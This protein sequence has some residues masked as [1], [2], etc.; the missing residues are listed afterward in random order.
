MSPVQQGPG[1][2]PFDI[3]GSFLIELDP[4]AWLDWLG[5]PI[6]GPVQSIESHVGTVLAEVD[7]VLRIDAP[8]PWLAHIE[9]PT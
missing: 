9:R 7:K 5:L 3:S 4:P 2:R 8:A 6:D 1:R